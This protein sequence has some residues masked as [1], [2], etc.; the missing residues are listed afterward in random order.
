MY[1]R[2]HVFCSAREATCPWFSSM[3]AVHGGMFP[4]SVQAA[5]SASIAHRPRGTRRRTAIGAFLVIRFLSVDCVTGSS[6]IAVVLE[7][8]SYLQLYIYLLI[9]GR[10]I[11]DPRPS[12]SLS[13]TGWCQSHIDGA[14]RYMTILYFILFV[15]VVVFNLMLSYEDVALILFVSSQL[16]CDRL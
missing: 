8:L 15:F 3:I 14:W 4:W 12:A 5:A 10:T 6:V 7:N 2:W 1:G 9:N 13:Y 11:R 16:S